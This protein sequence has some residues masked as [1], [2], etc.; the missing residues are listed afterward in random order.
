MLRAPR[1]KGRAASRTTVTAAEILCNRKCLLAVAAENGVGLAL[2]LAPDQW[3]MTGQL[4][5]AFY[6]GIKCVAAFE[7]HSHNIEFRVVVLTLSSLIN[8]D[9][10]D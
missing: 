7:S 6:A 4:F 5:V 8:S 3:H 9:T 2:I 10:A 1:V